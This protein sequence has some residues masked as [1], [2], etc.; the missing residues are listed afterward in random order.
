[1]KKFSLVL[2]QP[3]FGPLAPLNLQSSEEAELAETFIKLGFPTG[4]HERTIFNFDK[5]G[6]IKAL[7]RLVS[8]QICKY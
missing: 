3:N 4:F 5:I 7:F 2:Q 6:I 1:M 8:P